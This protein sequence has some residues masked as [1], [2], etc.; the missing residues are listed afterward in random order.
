MTASA[1]Y[2]WRLCEGVELLWRAW[3]DDV[4]VFNLASN[5]THLLDAFSA[6]VLKALAAAPLTPETL[7]ERF[8]AELGADQ[9]QV[10]ERLEVA[11]GRFAELGLIER[12]AA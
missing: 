10:S 7:T 12:R 8:V 5:Q 9:A 2:A 1:P 11:C 3:D 4:V 6:A